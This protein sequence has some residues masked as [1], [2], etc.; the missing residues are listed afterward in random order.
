MADDSGPPYTTTTSQTVSTLTKLHC[1]ITLSPTEVEVSP[2]A[3][4]FYTPTTTDL[5]YVEKK[6][7]SASPFKPLQLKNS[8]PTDVAS[9]YATMCN[10]FL[11]S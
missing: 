6:R 7:T 9:Q 10:I 2:A 4:R 1:S 3:D 8:T 5:S 11:L